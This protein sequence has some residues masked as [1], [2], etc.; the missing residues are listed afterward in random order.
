MKKLLFKDKE[1]IIHPIRIMAAPR[2]E[3]GY[4]H[5]EVISEGSREV[6]RL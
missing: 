2:K 5:V 6:S 4:D 3:H 1:I